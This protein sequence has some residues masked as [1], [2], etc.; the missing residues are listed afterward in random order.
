LS[1]VYN[2]TANSADTKHDQIQLAFSEDCS[3]LINY[4]TKTDSDGRFQLLFSVESPLY[5][6]SYATTNYVDTIISNLLGG[7]GPSL[8][9][10][11]ELSKSL[12][13]DAHFASTVTNMISSIQLLNKIS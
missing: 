12:N 7:V 2:D 4:Y 3:N 6:N 11:N 9:T 13:D 8:D 5:L 1:Q 10:L